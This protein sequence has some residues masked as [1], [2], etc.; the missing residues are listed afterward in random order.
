MATIT[1]ITATTAGATYTTTAVVSSDKFLNTGR[2]ALIVINGS[3][4]SINVTFT[5]GGT[6]GGLA[7]A[8][9]VVAVGAGVTKIIGPFNPSYWNDSSGFVNYAFSATTTITEA[10]IQ[11]N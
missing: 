10:V 7:L 9:V 5:P 1:A 6:P 2:E 3:G 11:V 4:S 8:P